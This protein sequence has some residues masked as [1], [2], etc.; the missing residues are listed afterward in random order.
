MRTLSTIFV[1]G[2]FATLVL[3]ALLLAVAVELLPCI[4][5]GCAIA[6]LMRCRQRPGVTASLLAYRPGVTS[7][8]QVVTPSGWVYVPVWVGPSPQ[9]AV[10]V[11]DAEVIEEP[12]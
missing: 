6:V 11:I 2:L 10:P 7:Q 5:I 12:R 4:A 9:P 3:G 1:V 8:P